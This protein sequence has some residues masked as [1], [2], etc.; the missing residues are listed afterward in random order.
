MKY[1]E[2]L[3]RGGALNAVASNFLSSAIGTITS[4]ILGLLF[5][6]VTIKVIFFVLAIVFLLLYL[7][8]MILKASY[9]FVISYPDNGHEVPSGFKIWGKYKALPTNRNLYILVHNMNDK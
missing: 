9:G 8:Y 2:I 3:F 5:P 4:F 7:L 6:E 1:L